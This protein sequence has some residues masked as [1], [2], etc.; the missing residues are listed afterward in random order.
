MA[1][2][3]IADPPK[4]ENNQLALQHVQLDTIP[5]EEKLFHPNFQSKYE[6]DDAFS[7][8]VKIGDKSSWWDRFK[9]WLSNFFKNLFN[10]K[11]A[12]AASNFVDVLIKI[13]AGCLIVFVIYLIVKSI[14]NGEG[15]WIFGKSSDKKVIQYEDVERNLH[16]VNFEQ[17]IKQSLKNNEHRLVIRYYYLWVLKTM[18]EK[19]VIVWDPEKTNS[20]YTLEIQNPNIKE[21]FSYASYLY[22]YIW[23]G[24]FELE[25]SAFNKAQKVFENLIKS[26]S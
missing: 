19:G 26:V 10:F 24:E 13:I 17:L 8:E 11:D 23:Y 16:L 22:N 14:M 2:D 7:Y 4:I 25:E 9:E 1:Q 5:M 20:D 21:Q 15:Q 12:V 18:S 6:K 3:T